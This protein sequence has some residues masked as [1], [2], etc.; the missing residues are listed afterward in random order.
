MKFGAPML[1]VDAGEASDGV[2]T[3][4]RLL[5]TQTVAHLGHRD[6]DWRL[7]D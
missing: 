7:E 6:G 3:N 2:L 5:V 4:V 1:T